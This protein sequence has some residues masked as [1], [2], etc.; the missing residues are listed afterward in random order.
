MSKRKIYWWSEQTVT[1]PPKLWSADLASECSTS[2]AIP[3]TELPDLIAE[4][5]Q[6]VSSQTAFYLGLPI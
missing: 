1:Q 6:E 5:Y 2:H 4:G 3:D